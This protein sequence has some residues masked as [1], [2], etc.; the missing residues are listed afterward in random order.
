MLL[1]NFNLLLNLMKVLEKI[2]LFSVLIILSMVNNGIS[3]ETVKD[4]DENIYRTVKIGNQ[5][6]FAENLKTTHYKNGDNIANIMDSIQWN[7]CVTHS[8][9]NSDKSKW[10]VEGRGQWV[11]L[12]N[13]SN[14]N[15]I[16]GK[17]YNWFAVSD[18]RGLCPSGWHIPTKDEW[19]EL[20]NYLGGQNIAGE[21]LKSK[22]SW[23]EN[24]N[25]SDL[26]GFSARPGSRRSFLSNFGNSGN[27]AFF[28]SSTERC[29]R[30]IVFGDLIMCDQALSYTL[31]NKD[32]TVG[33][34]P[35]R[36]GEGF[37]CRCVKD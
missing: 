24:G 28:W 31:S 26:Y 2:I 30:G 36:K 12:K 23:A 11:Y 27:T 17:L 25:G 13:D 4:I 15:K 10:L 16:Y 22:E 1:I 33:Q 18:P 21:K 34:Y 6:W 7:K 20:I 37:S 9:Y 35:T 5:I 8:D 19:F 32:S 29:A 14:Y 3:Q